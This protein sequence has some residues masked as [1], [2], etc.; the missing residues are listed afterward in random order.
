MKSA[1]ASLKPIVQPN[2]VEQ[3]DGFLMRLKALPIDAA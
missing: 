2:H 1:T 3:I